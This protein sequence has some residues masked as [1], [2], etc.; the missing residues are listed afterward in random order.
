MKIHDAGGPGV[1]PNR[2]LKQ[3]RR[4]HE[5]TL[6]Q[7]A[8]YL[9]LTT[10]RISQIENG[11]SIPVERIQQW[12]TSSDLPT[13]IQSMAHTMWLAVLEQQQLAIDKQMDDLRTALQR[14]GGECSELTSQ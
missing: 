6:G 11:D 13:W 9:G 5:M 3:A 7:M 4:Q 1:N 8:R 12:S 2:I 10:Q 14:V